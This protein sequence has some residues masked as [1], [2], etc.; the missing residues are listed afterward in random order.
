MRKDKPSNFDFDHWA[1]IAARDAEQFESMR[2]EMI[3]ELI[4][5]APE[6]LRPRMEGL[7]W[8]IDQIRERSTNPM[9]ACLRISQQMWDNVLGER[10]LLTA[11]QQPEKIIRPAEMSSTDNVVSISKQTP[12]KSD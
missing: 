3:S 2:Q 1:N 7:Q 10:G 9:S 11:L 12:S 6:Y 5:N 4:E 8:Q